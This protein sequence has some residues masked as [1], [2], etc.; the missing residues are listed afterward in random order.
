M[1]NERLLCILKQ[2]PSNTTQYKIETIRPQLNAELDKLPDSVKLLDYYIKYPLVALKNPIDP[3]LMI[4]GRARVEP[5]TNLNR[6][7]IQKHITTPPAVE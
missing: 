4:V 3:V 5:A 1:F 2:G 6:F 7:E